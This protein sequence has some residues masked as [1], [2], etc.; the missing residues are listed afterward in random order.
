M[1]A[2]GVL[3]NC[4]NQKLSAI[5]IMS[6]LQIKRSGA[7][8]K[9]F[10]RL[11][12]RFLSVSYKTCLNWQNQL[13]ANFDSQVLDWKNQ[14][15]SECKEE[16]TSGTP[17]NH[18][19]YRLVGDNVDI[20][21]KP[22]QTSIAHASTDLHFFN[23]MAVK[24]RISGN[25]LSDSR[26]ES[27]LKDPLDWSQ[28]LPSVDDHQRLESHWTT[29]VGHII[30]KYIPSLQWMQHYIPEHIPHEYSDVTKKKSEVVSC[31][32]LYTLN[33]MVSWTPIP[34]KAMVEGMR[35]ESEIL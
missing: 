18:P 4:R 13:G 30:C 15:E 6:A 5:Q 8:S 22:R 7:G 23:L 10:A 17:R 12:H 16:A 24:N 14:V 34:I 20:M 9:A 31:Y 32:V 1:S 2:A 27:K 21:I 29:L 35:M 11:N 28:V 26:D 25:H 3:L 19:G 33:D